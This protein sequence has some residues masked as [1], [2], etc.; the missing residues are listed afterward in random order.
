MR[1]PAYVMEALHYVQGRRPWD[2]EDRETVIMF[3]FT[4]GFDQACDWLVV[5]RDLY[6]R[7]L[8]MLRA[9]AYE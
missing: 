4:Y 7:A 1:V 2:M 5:H 9:T 6:P 8:K 3:T